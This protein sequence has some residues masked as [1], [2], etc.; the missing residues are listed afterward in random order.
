[1]GRV[2][3]RLTKE[4]A[5]KLRDIIKDNPDSDMV[6]LHHALG[7]QLDQMWDESHDQGAPCLCGHSYY[8]HFD[9]WEDMEPIGCKYCECFNF[10]E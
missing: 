4:E 7:V 2:D 6:M 9:S 5:E 3:I 8:R 1:M 10:K